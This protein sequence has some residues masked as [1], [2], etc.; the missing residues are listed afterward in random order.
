[1]GKTFTQAV[2][3]RSLMLMQFESCLKRREG[4]S[5]EAYSWNNPCVML[6]KASDVI[7]CI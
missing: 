1:M 5:L 2:R 7:R 3:M 6:L 4:L